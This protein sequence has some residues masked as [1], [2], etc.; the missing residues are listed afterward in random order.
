M[1]KH[2][3][4]TD[5]ALIAAL[6]TT[7][8]ASLHLALFQ[9][10]NWD[11]FYY[12]SQVHDYARGTFSTA[13]QTIHIHFWRPL[14]RS[15]LNE[16][17]QIVIGRLTMWLSLAGTVVAIYACARAFFTR[18]A[19]L[20]AGLVY[21][22]FNYTLI[23]G[24]S[25]RTDPSAAFLIMVCLTIAMRAR[26]GLGAILVFAICA[27]F[28]AL[29]TVKVVFYLPAFLAAIVWR[30]SGPEQPM[31]LF[32]RIGAMLIAS[33]VLF[34]GIYAWHQGTLADANLSGTQS[35]L[36]NAAS[37]TLIPKN[38]FP[39]MPYL[40]INAAD[41]VVPTLILWASIPI[42]L[43][44]GPQLC[45]SWRAVC[46]ILLLALPLAT[47]VVYR[48]AFPYFFPFI[49]P[50][51]MVL[52]AAVFDTVRTR[53]PIAAALILLCLITT[54][55]SWSTRLDS[56]KTNQ[57]KVVQAVHEVFPE[58]VA[59]FDRSGVIAGFPKA[60]FFMSTWGV[61]NYRNAGIPLLSNAL[62]TQTVPLLLLNSPQL[63]HAVATDG[64]TNATP[65]FEEDRNALRNNFIPHWGPIWV[66]GKTLDLTGDEQSIKIKI[67]GTYTLEATA[68]ILVNG[69]PVHPRTQ[70][71][72]ARGEVTLMSTVPQSISLRWGVNLARPTSPAL[73]TP[74]FTDF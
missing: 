11:E 23:H 32:A 70:I 57:H 7:L 19:A 63:S 8:L 59:Y 56:P 34:A 68:P 46:V 40:L 2:F 25:F 3:E 24:T 38:L 73:D 15:S 44:K 31:M 21:L 55:L 18:S 69:T 36:S 49:F 12:L 67:P 10:I 62:K 30:L 27:A 66:A 5:L 64:R 41:S 71:T 48:N 28:A 43:L 9:K 17:D 39:R 45:G 47:F 42:L 52:C 65:L 22:S 26:L 16:V 6:G 60:G 13:L 33:L 4:K 1:F 50:P 37:T 74:F 35:M 72:V 54:A 29:I 61:L 53:T 51:A 58:P 20:F 14:T